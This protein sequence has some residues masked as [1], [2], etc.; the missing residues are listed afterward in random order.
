V[1][2]P[3]PEDEAVATGHPRP[4]AF[5]LTRWSITQLRK[6]LKLGGEIAA[7]KGPLLIHSEHIPVFYVVAANPTTGRISFETLEYLANNHMENKTE[8]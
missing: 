6:Q 8:N 4:V 1:S 3:T 5:E 7:N 2:E